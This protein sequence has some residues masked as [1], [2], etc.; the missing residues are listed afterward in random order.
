METEPISYLDPSREDS[1]GL[2][3]Y[4]YDIFRSQSRQFFGEEREFIPIIM[5]RVV[6]PSMEIQPYPRDHEVVRGVIEY[7]QVADQDNIG[8]I[9]SR[10][11]L[12]TW[13][14]PLRR[15]STLP[16]RSA[17]SP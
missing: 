11:K 16:I 12:P 14:I 9:G 13:P 2:G 5:S 7:A 6:Q 8:F 15:S 10:T 3:I 1:M 17:T 4:G